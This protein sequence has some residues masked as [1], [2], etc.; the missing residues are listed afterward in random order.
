MPMKPGAQYELA[1]DRC[2]GRVRMDEVK[3]DP[4]VVRDRYEELL[5]DEVDPPGKRRRQELAELAW[6]EAATGTTPRRRYVEWVKDGD[7]LYIGSASRPET[8]AAIDLFRKTGGTNIL[9]ATPWETLGDMTC[10]AVEA[11]HPGQSVWGARFLRAVAAS[12][13]REMSVSLE[14]GAASLRRGDLKL[15]LSGDIRAPLT[16]HLDEGAEVISARLQGQ[17][18][19]TIDGLSW[20]IKSL[21]LPAPAPS[22]HWADS[23]GTRLAAIRD[24]FEWIDSAFADL[25]PKVEEEA[26]EDGRTHIQETIP[27][28]KP[29]RLEGTGDE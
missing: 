18:L 24:A 13:S 21:A 6:C 22:A 29:G 10:D 25:R 16:H 8:S 14:E 11:N 17:Y 1:G 12:P 20:W 19:L 28:V 26:R 15:S 23:L 9:P 27:G 4:V 7:L 3:P 2:A 5:T